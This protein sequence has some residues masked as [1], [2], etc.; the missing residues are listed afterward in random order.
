MREENIMKTFTKIFIAFVIVLLIVF[1]ALVAY[2]QSGWTALAGGL[3]QPQ[4]TYLLTICQQDERNLDNI[5]VALRFDGRVTIYS[6]P[7]SGCSTNN[8]TSYDSGIVEW[9][10]QGRGLWAG[11]VEPSVTLSGYNHTNGIFLPVVGK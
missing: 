9:H 2:A 7:V 3:P 1:W 11:Y 8:H 5:D 4:G 6:V 10:S